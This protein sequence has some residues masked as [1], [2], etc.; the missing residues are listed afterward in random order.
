MQTITNSNDG[1]QQ[2]VVVDGQQRM[3]SLFMFIDN[4]IELP[5]AAPWN[6][7]RF[8]DLNDTE[9]QVLWNYKVVVRQINTVS[10]AEIRDLFTRLNTN[11]VALNDQELRNARYI[12]KFKQSAER[13][14]DNTF[15]QS[16]RLF[17]AREIRRMEDV[18]YVS[19]LL[20]LVVEGIINKKDLLDAV[21]ARYE[22]EFPRA[23]E[24]EEDFNG[25]LQLLTTLVNVENA[26]LI[27]TKSNFYSLF[28]TCLRYW[29]AH[30]RPQ[31]VALAQAQ[32]EITALLLAAK[33]FDPT[34]LTNTTG[35]VQE[36]YDAVSRAASDKS[37]RVK[38]EE[39]LWNIISSK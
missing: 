24:F 38:R 21:Y 3:K 11:T 39:I 25:A 22:A 1:T 8:R 36:Y 32:A 6:A 28:G 2:F 15:F 19:E 29:R 20:L 12:G 31:F 23:A 9:K 4:E 26:T 7:R 10:D 27:K 30:R 13:L 35:A 5:D 34:I 37:R 18:E 14:A 33:S 16:V 17:T